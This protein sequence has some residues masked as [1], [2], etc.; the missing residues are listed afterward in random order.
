MDFNVLMG[1]MCGVISGLLIFSIAKLL[2]L[3][4]IPQMI[5]FIVSFTTFMMI[6]QMYVYP[7]H[8]LSEIK[9]EYPLFQLIS[10]TD[11]DAYNIFISNIERDSKKNGKIT[12]EI[13]RKN[14]SALISI[15]FPK[16]LKAAPDEEIYNYLDATIKFYNELYDISP[17]LILD[18]EYGLDF[19]KN[20][21][22]PQEALL[23]IMDTK[24]AIIQSASRN[25]QP[26]PTEDEALPY[27]KTIIN[28]LSNKY[29]EKIVLLFLD[30]KI[31]TLPAP[32]AASFLIDFYQEIYNTGEKSAGI[33]IRYIANA[34]PSQ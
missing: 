23:Q 27:F 28:N 15:V 13:V 20:I 29:G 4:K 17:K 7:K 5:L 31:N 18:I 16:Y 10:N 8:V 32:V 25:P 6:A 24:A 2:R 30:E 26:L 33:I 34:A 1:A 3:G 12:Q 19:P 9:K 21:S 22:I 14:S 11:P